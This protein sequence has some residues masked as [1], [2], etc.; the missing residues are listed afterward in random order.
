MRIISLN[1]KDIHKGS[2]ILIN[3][4][5]PLHS[6][7]A[8]YPIQLVPAS[9]DNPEILLEMK[10]ATVLSHLLGIIKGQE[11]IVPVSGY[12]SFEEQKRLYEDAMSTH[13]REFT[14]QYVA[15]PNHSEH[16]TGLAI[17]LAVDRNEIDFI[18]PEFPYEGICNR[19]REK[20]SLHGFI[21]RYRKGKENI[22]GIAHEPWHFRYVGYPHSLLMQNYNMVLEEYVEFLKTYP[23][24]G[25]HLV[26][27]LNQQRVE[28]FFVE[29]NRLSNYTS[30]ELPEDSIYQLSGNN[31]DGFIVTVWI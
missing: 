6:R 23:Y 21:E 15:A 10:T 28:I 9:I 20:A 16:Q 4:H 7:P 18:R 1:K 24:K 19:F 26:A 14:E 11:S 2:L 12:R 31:V 13:G 17:D 30:I 5:Y 8:E 29:A 22:T 3:K 25:E 27:E